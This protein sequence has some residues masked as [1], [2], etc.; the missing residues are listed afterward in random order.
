M[1]IAEADVRWVKP[2]KMGLLEQLYLPAIVAGLQTT[3]KHIVRMPQG[4]AA[5]S[6]GAARS[7]RRT[8]AACI[9][10]TAT[11]RAAS[12]AWPA[13]CARPPARPTA[14]TSWPPRRRWPDREKYPE[15]FVIDELRCIYC[16]MCEQACPVDAIELTTLFDLTGLSREEMMFDKEK[17]LSVF[18]ETVATRH[19]PG[20]DA[21]GPAGRRLG[22][23]GAGRAARL[24]DGDDG[25]NDP[26]RLPSESRGR[27]D[28]DKT[29]TPTP[30]PRAERRAW[31]GFILDNPLLASSATCWWTTG[32]SRCRRSSGSWRSICCCRGRGRRA[33]ALGTAVAGA[34]RLARPAC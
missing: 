1:P 9:G 5:V 30:L 8:I 21:G 17:L 31:Y 27:R 33:A 14:S 26:P 34:V 20:A 15:T 29:L 28:E 16:G 6:R 18:D 12:S 10:S 13:T 25:V 7:C 23:G 11:S 19:R 22:A 32:P 3:V 24:V 2:P 4:H